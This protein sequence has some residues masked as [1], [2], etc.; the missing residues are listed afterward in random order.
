MIQEL[1]AA[2][3]LDVRERVDACVV[4]RRR[5][6]ALQVIRSTV[7]GTGIHEGLE[8]VLARTEILAD[9]L[10][11][12]PAQD[13]DT[14]TG[15]ARELPG[16]PPVALRLEWDGDTFGWMLELGA[17]LAGTEGEGRAL[18]LW[19]EGDW[20]EPLATAAALAERLGVP[21]HGPG[22]DGPAGWAG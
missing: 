14:L 15:L 16:G 2:L 10:E 8:L 3:P 18:A 6:E 21:L 4:R 9:R 17:V 20:T 5:I 22:D 11:P 13:L 1:W 7:A 19:R 12:L